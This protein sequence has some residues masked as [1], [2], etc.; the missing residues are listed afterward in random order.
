MSSDLTLY[1]FVYKCRLCERRYASGCCRTTRTG[2]CICM[3]STVVESDASSHVVPLL[4]SHYCGDGGYGVADFIG[5]R[6]EIES[7]IEAGEASP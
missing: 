4:T 7:S 5:A 1:E 2:I 6:P 3:A